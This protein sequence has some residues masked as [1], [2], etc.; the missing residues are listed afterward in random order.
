MAK[1]RRRVP[2]KCGKCGKAFAINYRVGKKGGR[3]LV[4]EEGGLGFEVVDNAKGVIS[5]VCPE[6]GHL[7][8]TTTAKVM[9][10]MGS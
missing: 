3:Q 1:P 4:V 9:G 7:T 6:C 2:I 8:L 10:G 5:I